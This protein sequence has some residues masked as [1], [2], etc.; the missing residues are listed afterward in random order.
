M[1]ET[2][3]VRIP[4][5]DLKMIEEASKFV[6]RKRSDVLRQIVELGVKQVMLEIAIEKFQKN[7]ATASKAASIAGIPLTL[8]LDVLVERKMDFHYTKEDLRKDFED[9]L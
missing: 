4:K 2:I 8:F 6:K 1:E 7:E 9:L 3:S 5:E